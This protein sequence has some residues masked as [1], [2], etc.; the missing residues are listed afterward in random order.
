MNSN[1]K[2]T[3]LRGVPPSLNRQAG[4][5]HFKPV[6]AQ[7]KTRIA[8]PGTKLPVA[9]PVYRPATTTP[10]A[11]QPK[12][13]NGAVNRNLPIAPSAFRPQVPGGLQTKRSQIRPAGQV[14]HYPVAPPLYR[15]EAKK[16]VQPKTISQHAKIA[17]SIRPVT[18]KRTASPFR[19]IQMAEEKKAHECS[20]KVVTNSGE[21]TGEYDGIHAEINA[22]EKYFQG[23]GDIASITR[24]ELSS[25]PCKYCHIILF[26]LGILGKV[27]TSDKRKYGRCQGG[28]YGWFKRG[29]S[30]WKAVKAVTSY[31]GDEDAYAKNVCERKAKLK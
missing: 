20:A 8:A 9:P 23:G 4:L 18:A 22:L 30:V 10:N 27:V 26:D 31:A 13:A 17:N 2:P 21:H 16:I 19:A 28:S 29:G 5:G 14:A 6:V 12:M 15:P 11:A 25:S 24:I 7:L 1:K 3:T